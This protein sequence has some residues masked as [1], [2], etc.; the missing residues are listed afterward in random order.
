MSRDDE[1]DNSDK[2]LERMENDL[3]CHYAGNLVPIYFVSFVFFSFVFLLN[4]R[5]DTL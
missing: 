5:N 1:S 4:R 3:S 2:T